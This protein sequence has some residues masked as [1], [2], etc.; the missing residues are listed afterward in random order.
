[1]SITSFSSHPNNNRGTET[2]QS[3]SDFDANG[4]LLTLNN[5]G[6]LDWHYNNTLNQLTKADSNTTQYY[7]Y[8]HQ[9]NRV[10]TVTESNPRLLFGWMVRVCCQVL[11][12]AW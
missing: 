9:G 1:V 3:T 7:I 10:R 8:D 5:I 12:F 11:L 2:Q 6:T 4:N